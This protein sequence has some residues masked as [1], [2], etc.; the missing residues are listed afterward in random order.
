MLTSVLAARRE[1]SQVKAGAPIIYGFD[2]AAVAADLRRLA[3]DSRVS[4]F[5]PATKVDTNCVLP[6][7]DMSV[8]AGVPTP[9][10]VALLDSAALFARLEAEAARAGAECRTS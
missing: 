9:R 7:T 8:I 6:G 1:L 2:V 3:G 10:D 4:R 5:E